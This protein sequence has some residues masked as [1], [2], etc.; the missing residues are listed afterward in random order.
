M[1]DLRGFVVHVLGRSRTTAGVLE[2]ALKYIH[3]IK[4]HIP[5]LAESENAGLG[6]H[7]PDPLQRI[8]KTNDNRYAESPEASS[9]QPLP[10]SKTSATSSVP[11]LGKSL[12]V[13][14]LSSSDLP[15]PLLDPRRTFIAS[16]I[17][18]RKFTHDKCHS[19]LPWAKLVSLPPR[20]IGRCERALADALGW[21]LWVGNE[22]C[23][24]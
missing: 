5:A 23:T 3:N 9:P 17:L 6:D 22:P 20:E 15:S 13:K 4:S 10:M 24:S 19:N 12:D 21:H 16:L 14:P 11:M 1:T 7:G 8:V 2:W 18:A